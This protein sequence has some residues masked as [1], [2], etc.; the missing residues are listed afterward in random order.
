MAMIT[1]WARG[2]WPTLNQVGTS[3]WRY[4]R[5]MDGQTQHWTITITGRHARET[6]T[7]GE[8]VIS[9]TTTGLTLRDETWWIAHRNGEL[10]RQGW[11][12]AEIVPAS[13]IPSPAP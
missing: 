2:L 6:W 9:D 3:T 11:R 8:H 5:Q 12:L 1:L 4:S 13:R 7:A 10:H